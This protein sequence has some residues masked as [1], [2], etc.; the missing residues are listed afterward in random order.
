LII[1]RKEFFNKSQ[2]I[3]IVV[4]ASS[5]EILNVVEAASSNNFKMTSAES[6]INTKYII[7][8]KTIFLK[9]CLFLFL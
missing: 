3:K 4:V 6:S 5:P 2:A 9:F 8:N 1:K 7:E